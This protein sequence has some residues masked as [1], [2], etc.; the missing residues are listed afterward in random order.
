MRDR[1]KTYI[2]ILA[3]CLAVGAF[4]LVA[5]VGVT[6]LPL[7]L[8]PKAETPSPSPADTKAPVPSPTD[9]GGSTGGAI[10]PE[11]VGPM[12]QDPTYAPNG[13]AIAFV[14]D[15]G[16]GVHIWV[17]GV[18][19][20]RLRQLTS[21]LNLPVGKNRDLFPTWSPDGS[22]IAFTSNIAGRSS[23]WV[24]NA[25]GSDRRQLTTG[26]ASDST[27]A[28]SPDGSQ[29]AFVSDRS[30][31]LHIWI[32]S[33]DGTNPR[34]VTNLGWRDLY[35]SF[36]PDGRQ[37][38]FTSTPGGRSNPPSNLWIVNVDGTGLRQLTTGE[39]DDF[40]PRWSERGI[41]FNSN[42]IRGV[43]GGTSLRIIQPDGSGMQALPGAYGEHPVW[44]PD[45]ARIAFSR[46]EEGMSNIHEFN[47]LDHAIRPLTQFKGFVIAIEI[48]PGASPKAINPRSAA[49][50][51]VAILSTPD[52]DPV[53]QIDQ[54][55][56]TFGPTGDE[57][58]LA[59]CAADEV[60]GDG[61]PD[62][63]CHFEI[64]SAFSPANT[65]GILRAMNVSRFRLEGRATVSVVVTRP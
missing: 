27:P 22:L 24:V 31:S 2:A 5:F 32:M 36:S 11:G 17:I 29:L 47:F 50:I 42:R 35:P 23:I 64:G 14:T 21:D 25:D 30:G 58:S 37:L 44:S 40:H 53:Q 57:R 19:G 13:S 46:E 18:D 38:V 55:S 60:N 20:R 33:A 41:V 26:P 59:F 65:E 51:P 15:W 16:G 3:S 28:W 9:S 4:V 39:F 49:R 61:I 54:T 56:I 12:S 52:F 63:V 34:R 43:P 45:G 48:M 6:S 10:G 8:G 62:L 1:R 7:H